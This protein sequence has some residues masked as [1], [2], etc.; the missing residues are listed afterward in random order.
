M[1]F[2]LFFYCVTVKTIY[3]KKTEI[4]LVLNLFSCFSFFLCFDSYVR[5]F[6][7]ILTYF[8]TF[9][10]CYYKL[11]KKRNITPGLN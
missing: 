8:M 5:P 9:Y 10:L 4:G 7:T 3:G 6:I 1:V 2:D 11:M